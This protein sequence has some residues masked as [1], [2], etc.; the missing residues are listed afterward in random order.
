MTKTPRSKPLLR[1]AEKPIRSRAIRKR[2]KA[3]PGLPFESMP[4]RVEPAL[5]LLKQ[6]PPIGDKWGWEIKWDGYR[7]AVHSDPSGVRVFTRGGYDWAARFPTIEK[8][9]RELG[10]ASFIIDGEA[11]VLDEQGRS[12]F[13]ALQK[14]LGAS[15]ARSGK[16]IADNAV[17]YVF[18]L[19]YFDGRDLRELPYRNR[20]LMLEEMLSGF[21]GAI[22][23]S[24]EVDTDDPGNMLKH[25]CRLGLEGIIGKDRTS[26]YRSGR[27]GDWV[28]VKCVQSE[29]FLIVGYEPSMSAACGFASLLLAAYDGDD[30]RYVGSV[31]T[32]FKERVANEL[33]AMFDKLPWRKKK[34]PVAYDGRGDVVWLQPTLIAE[35]EFRQITADKKLRHAVYNGLRERQDNADVYRLD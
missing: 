11:V 1:D 25:A 31:G 28:K 19:L 2:N 12:D 4:D 7:L 30:L 35:I 6:T 20:R 10:P 24:E 13:N 18:D 5:A 15:G 16:L 33:S 8:A 17:L 3:Q 29:P 22:R 32:G 27:T 23:V 26:P 21:E 9:A 34:P 14:S